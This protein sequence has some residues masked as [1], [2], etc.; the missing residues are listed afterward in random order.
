MISYWKLKSLNNDSFRNELLN[1]ELLHTPD[2]TAN[3]FASQ[4]NSVVTGILDKLRAPLRQLKKCPSKINR[5]LSP[6]ATDAKKLRRR[7]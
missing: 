1:S 6:D 5:W 7:H 4:I 3:G 2:D